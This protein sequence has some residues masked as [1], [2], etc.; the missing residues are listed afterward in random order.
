MTEKQE[1]VSHFIR[2]IRGISPQHLR[3]ACT[4]GGCHRFFLV[5]KDRFPSAVPYGTA[6]D[7]GGHVVAKICGKFWDIYGEHVPGTHGTVEKFSKRSLVR[8][9]SCIFDEGYVMLNP[10]IIRKYDTE[11]EEA[12]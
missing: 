7:G 4:H 8:M 3:Y 10:W 12:E 9:S 2:L 5:L 1:D 6:F 11:N